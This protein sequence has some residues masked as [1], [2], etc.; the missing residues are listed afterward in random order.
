MTFPAVR[1][2]TI[3]SKTNTAGALSYTLP[4]H[5]DGDILL[6][7]QRQAVG[8]DIWS[9]VPSGWTA[10]TDDNFFVYARRATSSSETNPSFTSTQSSLRARGVCYSI[11]GVKTGALADVI[12]IAKSSSTTAPALS[13]SWGV[14]DTCWIQ[15]YTVTNRDITVSFTTSLFSWPVESDEGG[16][17][18]TAFGTVFSYRRFANL[19]TVPAHNFAPNRTNNAISFTIALRPDVAGTTVEP[20]TP[21]ISLI[22]RNSITGYA[23]A[24]TL[25]RTLPAGIVAGDLIVIAGFHRSTL[26]PPAG[27]TVHEE[28]DAGSNGQQTFIATKVAD[29]TESSTTITFTQSV[30][31]RIALQTILLRGNDR[32]LEVVDVEKAIYTAV[33]GEALVSPVLDLAGGYTVIS[34]CSTVLAV[35]QN[36]YP[37]PTTASDPRWTRLNNYTAATNLNRLS[38]SL[39]QL[40]NVESYYLQYSRE[41]LGFANSS[42]VAIAVKQVPGVTVLSAIAATSVT[43]TSVVPR[44]TVTYP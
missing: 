21:E 35:G 30:S 26:T 27:F 14:E 31:D 29:G 28:A 19:A 38:S 6:I 23:V 3:A 18:S 22:F 9:S 7:I 42:I 34:A 24:T 44:V 36:T 4:T 20:P 17:S 40:N 1:G 10:L 25:T 16:G 8:D 32:A 2:A 11:S 41:G 39:V 37:I 13:P 43:A 15:T 33:S 5:Q 12:A